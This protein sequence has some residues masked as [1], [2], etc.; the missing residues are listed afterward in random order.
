VWWGKEAYAVAAGASTAA[1]IDTASAAV[2][3]VARERRRRC[4]GVR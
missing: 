4:R 3:G 1:A 2:R